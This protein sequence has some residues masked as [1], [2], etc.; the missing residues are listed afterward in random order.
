MAPGLCCPMA[1]RILVLGL[2]I[3]PVS[4]KLAGRF[5]TTGPPGKVPGGCFLSKALQREVLT[6]EMA[7][8]DAAL[9]HARPL[10]SQQDMA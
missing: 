3:E 7:N 9:L 4:P 10:G 1:C 6:M 5:L 8:W 2:G